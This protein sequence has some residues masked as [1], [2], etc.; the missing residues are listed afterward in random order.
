MRL[1]A[2]LLCSLILCARR[3]IRMVELSIIQAVSF[4]VVL[5]CLGFVVGLRT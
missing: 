1:A 5:L 2:T 3:G 4:S